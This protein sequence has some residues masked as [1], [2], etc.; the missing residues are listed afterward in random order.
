MHVQN[1][2]EQLMCGLVRQRKQGIEIVQGN[3]AGEYG[4]WLR[5]ST[6]QNLHA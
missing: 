6:I 3:D 2:F 4:F 1:S 5:F